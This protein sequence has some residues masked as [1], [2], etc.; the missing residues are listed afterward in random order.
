[1]WQ[2][3]NMLF[4]STYLQGRKLKMVFP[5]H[6]AHHTYTAVERKKKKWAFGF[7]ESKKLTYV[8][9]VC[10]TWGACPLWLAALRNRKMPFWDTSHKKSFVWFRERDSVEPWRMLRQGWLQNAFLA[11][12]GFLQNPFMHARVPEHQMPSPPLHNKTQFW[13]I[14][15]VCRRSGVGLDNPWTG[16]TSQQQWLWRFYSCSSKQFVEMEIV[17]DAVFWCRCRLCRWPQIKHFSV[18]AY[19]SFQASFHI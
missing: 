1:M 17:P 3:G 6:L 14:T 2:Y 12:K 7:L 19:V 5:W 9:L 18:G 10:I 13:G 11:W 4:C 15:L 16:I 8:L